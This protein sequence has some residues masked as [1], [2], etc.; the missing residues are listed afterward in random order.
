M[1]MSDNI[2]V[3]FS[4]SALPRKDP[5]YLEKTLL[6]QQQSQATSEQLH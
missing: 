6:D 2:L 5:Q 1:P 4:S 3:I